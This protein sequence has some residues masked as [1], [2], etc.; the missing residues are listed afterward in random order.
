[1]LE[2]VPDV[3][4]DFHLVP[5]MPLLPRGSDVTSKL[6]PNGLIHGQLC[7][8]HRVDMRKAICRHWK[9]KRKKMPRPRYLE[10]ETERAFRGLADLKLPRPRYGPRCQI[11]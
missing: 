4:Q 1:M 3:G 11:P 9:Y 2:G 8:W 6:W 7:R 5:K 10:A